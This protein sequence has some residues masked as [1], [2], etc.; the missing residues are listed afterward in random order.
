MADLLA[1][2]RVHLDAARLLT[3]PGPTVVAVSGG[4]DSV[5]LLDLLTRLAP[6]RRLE[7]VV[8]HADH[9]IGQGSGTVAAAVEELARPYGVPFELGEL[10]LGSGASETIAR[11][12]R[13]AWL[14]EVQHRYGARYLVTAHHRDDQ[15]ETILLRVL[16]G[17]APAGLAGMAG[18]GRDGLVRPLLPFA[19]RALAAYVAERDLDAHDDPANRDPRHLRSWVRHSLLPPLLERLGG[20]V[21]DD[22]LRVGRH[23]ADERRAW[24]EALELVPVLDLRL[25]AVGFD[26]A[27]GVRAGYHKTLSVA[28]LRAEGRRA[29]VRIGPRGAA[30]L[31]ALAQGGSGRRAELGAGWEGEAA[32][33]RLVVQRCGAVVAEPVVATAERGAAAF[34]G[35]AVCWAPGHAPERLERGGWTTWVTQAGW[36]LRPLRPG[37]RLR[38]LGGPG[39]RAVRRLLSEARVPRSRRGGYP[40]LAR[41]ETI[42][43]VPGICRSADEV[44]QPGTAAVRVDVTDDGAAQADRGA[45]ARAGGVR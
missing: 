32:F 6:E 23:A 9:G 3:R 12:A 31:A 5:A 2:L 36:E 27:R 44:P 35:F 19:R 30:R 13:Y 20:R 41:G 4:P 1:R 25:Q 18:R 15:V 29:G 21:A 40:I 17:S 11:R 43:W 14:R 16:R 8:A 38:P 34:G 42:L 24:D 26:V 22:V 45:P 37:D 7:V 33:D 28:L 39:G 10:R